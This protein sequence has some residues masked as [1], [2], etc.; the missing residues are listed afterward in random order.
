LNPAPATLLPTLPQSSLQ[1]S[2][3]RP[4]G[5][6]QTLAIDPALTLLET[7][8]PSPH[9]PRASSHMASMSSYHNIEPM[10]EDFRSARAPQR[11]P[12]SPGEVFGH[13]Y[14]HQPQ[15]S[16][17][18]PTRSRFSNT[19]PRRFYGRATRLRFSGPN[20]R[21]ILFPA[22]I[23]PD[24]EVAQVP[25]Q[26]AIDLGWG[27]REPG[28][29]RQI[30]EYKEDRVS[31]SSLGCG[32]PE[33]FIQ[34]F[35]I[36]L[37]PFSMQPELEV[38]ICLALTPDYTALTPDSTVYPYFSSVDLNEVRHYWNAPY[39]VI[40]RPMLIKMMECGWDL[41]DLPF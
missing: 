15:R 26:L 18:P 12:A 13:S 32:I 25:W 37:T 16:R 10:F 33:W 21:S 2:F 22:S 4:N 27:F 36:H 11:P 23:E 7:G 5:V 28:T 38:K 39:V 6:A 41:E 35:G 3:T 31:N 40:S 17:S 24:C 1:T 8:A 19:I 30:F 14:L 34:G 20:G 9:V 29:S